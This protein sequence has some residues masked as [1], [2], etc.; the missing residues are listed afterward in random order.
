MESILNGLVV[1][2]M[3]LLQEKTGIKK[4]K[5]HVFYVATS[6]QKVSA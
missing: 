3:I 2:N 6:L 4:L 5:N 1:K